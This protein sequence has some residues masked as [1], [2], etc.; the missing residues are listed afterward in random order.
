VVL[1]GLVENAPLVIGLIG[2]TTQLEPKRRRI[3]I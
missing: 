2:R 1:R 3:G